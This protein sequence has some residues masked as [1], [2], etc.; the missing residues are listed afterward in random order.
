MAKSLRPISERLWEKVEKTPTCWL[1]RGAT[2]GRYGHL[3]AGRAGE[4]NRY[5]HRVAYELLVGE[6]PDGLTIDHLCKNP[7]CVNPDHLEAVTH[8]ANIMRGPGASAA[9]A[10]K[11][12]CPQGH[13]FDEENTYFAPGTGDRRC[14]TCDK[15]RDRAR[16]RAVRKS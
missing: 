3:G 2:N 9:N 1:W 5:A 8:A 16:V 6:I 12:H 10:R 13:P 4:G 14:R 11:T 7:L 15:A